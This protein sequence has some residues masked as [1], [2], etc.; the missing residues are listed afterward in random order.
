MAYDAQA[1]GSIGW[2]AAD[3][4]GTIASMVFAQPE[5]FIGQE[6]HLCADARSI[7]ECRNIYREI[8]GKNPSRLPIP[9]WLFKLMA[10]QDLVKMCNWLRDSSY[11]PQDALF[12]TRELYP[13]AQDLSAW[14]KRKFDTGYVK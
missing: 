1:A 7:R 8:T 14:L 6:L 3:D 10:G 4:V 11:D 9:V 5:R 12:V 2:I 13:E